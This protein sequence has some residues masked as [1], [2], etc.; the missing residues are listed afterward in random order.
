MQKSFLIVKKFSL[1]LETAFRFG[2]LHSYRVQNTKFNLDVES[3]K[4]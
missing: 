2:R 4:I 1:M 3:N